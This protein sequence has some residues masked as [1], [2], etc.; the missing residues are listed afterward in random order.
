MPGRP[1]VTNGLRSVRLGSVAV[2][3]PVRR[4]VLT[5]LQ[6]QAALSCRGYSNNLWSKVN[7][8]QRSDGALQ[9]L[10]P[11]A[12]AM[13][14]GGIVAAV[15]PAERVQTVMA[16]RM[17]RDA[18]LVPH[19]DRID[20]ETTFERVHVPIV[21]D[22]GNLHCEGAQV[23]HMRVGEVWSLDVLT[24]HA[25]ACFSAEPRTHVIVDC[26]P[27]TTPPK[28]LAPCAEVVSMPV[29]QAFTRRKREVV[30]GLSTLLTQRNFER[31]FELLA[32]LPFEYDI[33]CVEAFDLMEAMCGRAADVTLPARAGEL[34][35]RCLSPFDPGPA[36]P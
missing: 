6:D 33:G 11:P 16:F 17:K 10:V 30:L 2:D 21:S 35:R 7:L 22:P 3:E 36:A 29:R 32:T 1:V 13:A 4:A 8:A 20:R 5:G 15:A 9:W 27:G 12:L 26:L 24:P 25:A 28:P 19:V 23:F 31:V 18:I 14:A 34:R